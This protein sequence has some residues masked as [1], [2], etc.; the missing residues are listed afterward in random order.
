MFITIMSVVL[1]ISINSVAYAE[2]L[3]DNNVSTTEEYGLSNLAEDVI[4]KEKVDDETLLY[5]NIDEFTEQ[6]K[7]KGICN[8]DLELGTFIAKYTNQY[9]DVMEK[10]DLC[11]Y[12]NYSKIYSSESVMKSLPNGKSTLISEQQAK[13]EILIDSIK[14]KSLVGVI[15]NGSWTSPNG[16]MKINT[17]ANA[18]KNNKKKYKVS[19]TAKWLK[20]PTNHSTDVLAIY[21]TGTFDDSVKEKGH[22]TEVLRCCNYKRR[23]QADGSYNNKNAKFEYPQVNI[24]DLRF[25]LVNTKIFTCN[26]NVKY[27]PKDVESIE[28]YLS[29][30]IILKPGETYNVQGAYCHKRF[31][32]GNI[33]VSISGGGPSFGATLKTVIDEYKARPITVKA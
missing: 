3:Q 5:L 26:N 11:D 17:S 32:A 33:S 7:S 14:A 28:A 29:Y 31:G 2:S 16:Y 4:K 24:V 12:V 6:A 20:M 22:L 27:H 10:A 19:S 9:S 1:V 23:Y 21:N 15:S 25:K 30:G 13:E 8:D 18:S